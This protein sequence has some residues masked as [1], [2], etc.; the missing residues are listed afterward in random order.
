MVV[1]EVKMSAHGRADLLGGTFGLAPGFGPI[2]AFGDKAPALG[3]DASAGTGAAG[4]SGGQKDGQ[5]ERPDQ[6]AYSA[7]FDFPLDR[8]RFWMA[9]SALRSP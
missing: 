3:R 8:K 9:R 6:R 7:F 1:V 4:K 2:D 5:K